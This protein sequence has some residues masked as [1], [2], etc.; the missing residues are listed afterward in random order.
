MPSEKR[1]RVPSG[2]IHFDADARVLAQHLDLAP[3]L[4]DADDGTV[5]VRVDDRHDEGLA[6]GV[7]TEP[8]D[9]LAEKELLDLV[10]RQFSHA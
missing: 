6:V 2:R 3:L 7:A 8:R 9:A 5:A 4:R 1:N 10:R